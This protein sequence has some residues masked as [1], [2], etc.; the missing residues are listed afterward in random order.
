[1]YII[2]LASGI[3]TNPWWILYIVHK[4]GLIL[5]TFKVSHFR[6]LIK[7]VA[8]IISYLLQTV[9]CS[10]SSSKWPCHGDQTIDLKHTL[11]V[12][13][14]RCWMLC[15]SLVVFESIHTFLWI[16]A[17]IWLAL[18]T[19]SSTW[20]FHFKSDCI[21]HWKQVYYYLYTVHIVPVSYA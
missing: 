7:L 15:N 17:N 16:M 3:L 4:L 21:L 19:F 9:W 2:H 20:W 12:A 13:E 5:Y 18:V 1:M 11:I 14:H 6:S 8:L 10:G